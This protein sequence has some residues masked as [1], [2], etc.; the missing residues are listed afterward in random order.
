[1]LQSSLANKFK[2]KDCDGLPSVPSP[3]A[4]RERRLSLLIVAASGLISFRQLLQY[5]SPLAG[6]RSCVFLPHSHNVR[7]R[8]LYSACLDVGACAGR[9]KETASDVV[10]AVAGRLRTAIAGKRECCSPSRQWTP[11]FRERTESSSRSKRLPIKV[12]R[13]SVLEPKW[14]STGTVCVGHARIT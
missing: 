2:G 1:M 4:H 10:I 14:R 12:Q 13:R 7:T 11:K 3:A 9:F 6:S 8:C 5:R